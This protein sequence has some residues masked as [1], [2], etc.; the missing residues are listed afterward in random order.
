MAWR[1]ESMMTVMGCK[2]D[3]FQD[4]KGLVPLLNDAYSH[5]ARGSLAIKGMK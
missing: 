3:L 1:L 4:D 5:L 2:I